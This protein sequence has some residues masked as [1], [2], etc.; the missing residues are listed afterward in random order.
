MSTRDEKLAEYCR[1]L[2]YMAQAG[3]GDD[4]DYVRWYET[5]LRDTEPDGLPYAYADWPS[6]DDRLSI[7]HGSMDIE[8]PLPPPFRKTDD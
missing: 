7:F 3:R 1:R 2:L 6:R 5:M 4:P 8:I